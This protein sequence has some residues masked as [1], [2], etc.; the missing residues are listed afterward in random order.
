MTHNAARCFKEE[1]KMKNVLEY[2]EEAAGRLP[3]KTAVID[4]KESC[5]YRKLQEISQTIGLC[6]ADYVLKEQPVAVFMKKSVLTLEVFFGIVYAGGF[7]SLL[8]PG[9]PTERTKKQLEVLRP[10]VVVTTPEYREKLAE[11]GYAGTILIAG[12][13]QEKNPED[14][15]KEAKE[16][17]AEIRKMQR[18][19]APLYCNFTSGSTGTPKGVLV[20]QDSVITFIDHFTKLFGITE[21]DV[22]G[23]QAPFDFDVSVKDIYSCMKTGA[24]MVIIPTAYFR[25]PNNVMDMMEEH[26]VTTLIWAVSALV[27]IN[28]LHEFMYKVPAHINKVLFSGEEMPAKHLA[29]W[30]RQYPK[31]QFV[32]LY[33]PTEITCNCTYYRIPQ[34]VQEGQKLP[35]GE[36]YPGKQITLWDEDGNVIGPEKEEVTGELC[37]SGDGLALGYYHNDAATQAA[38]VQRKMPDGTFKRIYKTGDLA[39][40]KDGRLYFAGRKD[41]QIKH[42]G[43]RIE[44]EEIERAMNALPQV[45]QACCIYDT[46]RYRIVAYYTGTE[47]KK[48]IVEGLRGRLPEYMLPNAYRFLEELPL[49]KNGKID[50]NQL[51]KQ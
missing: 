44:L 7:Y 51:R 4:D 37:V 22:I 6:L 16:R 26:K 34:L 48:G 18:P 49:T 2:M 40:R 8:D 13:L 28:R 3:D 32:N 30:M 1:T 47:D 25:F 50:R 21:Q 11:V 38:F 24:T 20:G 36:P 5:T 9:F 17:L 14:F 29:D 31:A 45:A 39:Y 46:E 33:G 19:E 42:N 43:H 12:E 23:N 15:S 10:Q 35:I 41:F 27:L